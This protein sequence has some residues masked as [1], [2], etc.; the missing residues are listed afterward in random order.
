[1]KMTQRFL[2]VALGLLAACGGSDGGGEPQPQP[3]PAPQ[4]A[5]LIFPDNNST[6][7]EGEILSPS[8]SRVTF[9][10]T[11]SQN[12]DSYQLVVRNLN[13]NQESNQ[14]PTTNQATLTLVRG[15]PYQWFVV[16]KAA[17]TNQTATSATWR[18]Y[19]EG[20]GISNYAPFPAEAVYPTR[21][22]HLSGAGALTLEWAGSDADDD[23]TDYE[24]FFGT[25]PAADVSAGTT[26]SS[27]LEVTVSA[28]QTYYWKVV[29]RD[30]A[31]NSSESEIFE[32][33][34]Q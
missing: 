32:F 7:L 28:G 24:V 26:A 6:C 33:L 25:A 2:G 19:N 13:T 17:G 15:T 18:F 16:S 12:T 21:G 9:Q 31:G 8:Q 20:P 5:T 4:A 11:A 22:A 30:S 23:I 1:M 29:T 34:V 27:T 10:W 14:T 3:I